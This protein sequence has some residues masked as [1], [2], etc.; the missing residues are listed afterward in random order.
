MAS[1]NR[2]PWSTVDA[3]ADTSKVQEPPTAF[4]VRTPLPGKVQ[5]KLTA[6]SGSPAN[7]S[8]GMTQA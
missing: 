6:A 1:P 5:S 7:I 2:P 3:R 8:V 4:A